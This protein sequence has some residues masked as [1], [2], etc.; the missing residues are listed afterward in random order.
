[1]YPNVTARVLEVNTFEEEVNQ[2]PL[3]HEVMFQQTS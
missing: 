2:K 1:M 3:P